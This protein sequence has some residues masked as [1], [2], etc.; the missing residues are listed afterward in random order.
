[1]STSQIPIR[2]GEYVIPSVLPDLNADLKFLSSF[3]A[4]GICHGDRIIMGCRGGHGFL[5][6]NGE[7]VRR[8]SGGEAGEVHVDLGENHHED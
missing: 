2:G 6:R 7:S 4:F 3:I 5:F 8:M 1:M